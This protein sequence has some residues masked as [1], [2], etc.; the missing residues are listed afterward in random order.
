MAN[1]LGNKFIRS[2]MSEIFVFS[3]TTII[4]LGDGLLRNRRHVI[5]CTND[6]DPITCLHQLKKNTL[7]MIWYSVT[8]V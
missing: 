2:F 1:N 3:L 5:T 8:S 6:D 4:D 7:F